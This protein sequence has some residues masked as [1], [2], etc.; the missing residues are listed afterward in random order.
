MSF[1]TA[2]FGGPTTVTKPSD[3]NLENMIHGLYNYQPG[4]YTGY[5]QDYKTLKI[6]NSGQDVSSLP[7]LSTLGNILATQNRERQRNLAMTSA[8]GLGG[9]PGLAAA[10]GQVG[11]LQAQDQAGNA[12]GN[13]LVGLQNS[14]QGRL[15][16]NSE[17]NKQL[18]LQAQQAATGYGLG[19]Y[20]Q[21]YGIAQQPGLLGALS[22]AAQGAGSILQGL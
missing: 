15:M 3:P 9:Q 13:A 21:R 8:L 1:L 6:I 7:Q 18:G 12:Y 5:R 17:L 4:N 16:Q 22:G 20:G 2:L 14:I 11:D 19:Y 10:I